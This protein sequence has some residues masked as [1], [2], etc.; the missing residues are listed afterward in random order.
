MLKTMLLLVLALL[1]SDSSIYAGA[2]LWN[3]STSSP[4][5]LALSYT[6]AINN[7]GMVVGSITIDAILLTQQ[8]AEV[9]ISAPSITIPLSGVPLNANASGINSSGQVS[10]GYQDLV[11]N[12]AFVW[13]STTGM[14]LLG[15]LGG[16]LSNALAINDADQI[17]GQTETSANLLQ[18]F[19]WSPIGGMVAVGDAGTYIAW[20]INNS[21]AMACQESPFPFTKDQ[22]AICGPNPSTVAVL[23]LGPSL[24]QFPSTAA[25]INDLGWII[26]TANGQGFIWT[27][28]GVTLL[29]LQFHPIALNNEGEIIGY[30][31]GQPAAWTNAGGFQVLPGGQGVFLGGLN[32]DGQIV[33]YTRLDIPE[34]SEFWLSAFAVIAM[35]AIRRLKK[36]NSEI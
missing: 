35:A 15:N 7:S 24:N 10:G 16:Q 33:G 3:T 2:L 18:A 26:G 22:A 32:D 14:Q 11:G 25:A 29:G 5:P 30:Y 28:G 31:N 34:P 19:L 6:G 27:A 13:S 4:S 23:N 12:H 1:L 8:A 9:S 20:D 17:V 21:G 36:G